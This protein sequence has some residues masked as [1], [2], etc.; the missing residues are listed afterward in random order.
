MN[1][2]AGG[3]R[4]ALPSDLKRIN[5][6]KILEYFR[7]GETLTAA[8]V[9]RMSGVSRPTVMRALQ[10]FCRTGAL[11]SAGIGSAA[12]RGGKKP[13]LFAFGDERRILAVNLWPDTLTFSLSPLAGE[14]GAL[15]RCDF[16]PK[17]G[18]GETLAEMK[19]LADAFLASQGTDADGLYGVALSVSGTV[20]YDTLT[21]RYDVNAPA[22]GADVPLGEYLRPLFGAEKEYFVDNAGKAAGRAVLLDHPE[23]AAERVVTLFTT[24]GVC[25]CMME[26]GHVLNGRDALIG[27]IGHSIVSDSAEETCAC[28]KRGCL[29]RMTRLDAVRRLPGMTARPELTESYGALFAASDA[30]DALAREA[31]RYLAHCFAVA[32]HNLALA[33]NPDRV[34]FQGDFAQADAWFD[35]CLKRELGE[36]NYYP[37]RVPFETGYDRRDLTLLAA[38]GGTA[39]MKRR[40]FESVDCD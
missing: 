30:G 20:D 14:M 13:E 36:F 2:T 5:R 6:R 9:H 32:L 33:Y 23:Y 12:A 25:A 10:Y 18:V 1:Q 28:G 37:N 22:W 34:I 11:K 40:Y 4:G 19:A 17:H 38:R 35:A 15:A 3:G 8:D 39:V 29:E 24:W 27:E 26:R 31:V 21:L 7:E 16:R